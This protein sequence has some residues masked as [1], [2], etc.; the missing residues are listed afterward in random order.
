[1]ADALDKGVPEAK[2][3]ER[4]GRTPGNDRVAIGEAHL[5]TSWCVSREAGRSRRVATTTTTEPHPG[6]RG[7]GSIIG[8]TL[9]VTAAH[10]IL[11]NLTTVV[12]H[13]PVTM[14]AHQTQDAQHHSSTLHPAHG[15]CQGVE[16]AAI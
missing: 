10:A 7:F 4:L 15:R 3:S 13:S 16:P 11:K 6:L 1:A 5:G 14:K 8:D 2:L 12:T 9:R